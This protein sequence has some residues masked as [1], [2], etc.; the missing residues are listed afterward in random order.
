MDGK[1]LLFLVIEHVD[2]FVDFFLTEV[3]GK[4]DALLE[5]K[6]ACIE[7]VHRLQS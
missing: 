3:V 5:Y 4:E 2:Y 7:C 1:L 6:P